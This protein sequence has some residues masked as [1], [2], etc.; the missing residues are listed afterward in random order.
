MKGQNLW[1][2]SV[3]AGGADDDDD[4]PQRL[5]G[6]DLWEVFGLLIEAQVEAKCISRNIV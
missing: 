4:R 5:H 1:M 2:L 6:P 3:G